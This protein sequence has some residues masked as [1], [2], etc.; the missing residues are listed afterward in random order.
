MTLNINF[1]KNKG[2]NSPA[3]PAFAPIGSVGTA[4]QMAAGHELTA[5][6]FPSAAIGSNLSWW[7]LGSTADGSGNGRSLLNANTA[8]FNATGILG[9]TNQAVNCSASGNKHL[10]YNTD[11]FF[12][13]TGAD[14]VGGAW[15]KADW[16]NIPDSGLFGDFNYDA[17]NYRSWSVNWSASAKEIILY[18]SPDGNDVAGYTFNTGITLASNTWN[19]IVLRYSVSAKTAYLY[20]NGHVVF[21]ASMAATLYQSTQKSFR[22]GG[23]SNGTHHTLTGSIDEFF[24]AKYML[25]NNDLSKIYARKYS[26]NQNT[27]PVSQK[28]VFQGQN[29]GQ[30]RELLDNIVDMQANDLYYDLSDESSTTQVS[31]RLANIY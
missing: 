6:S 31:L 10:Y 11:T 8:T 17:G 13:Y 20:I 29:G 4:G 27:P 28:W 21:T 24:F 5:A 14:F 12:S 3:A 22:L 7:N 1:A 15:F 18:F 30:T 23:Y 2:W 25:T 16:Q 26:H 9:D 19:H